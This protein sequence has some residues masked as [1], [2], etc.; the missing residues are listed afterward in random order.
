MAFLEGVVPTPTPRRAPGHGLPPVMLLV[1]APGI[2][3]TP[4]TGWVLLS[5]CCVLRCFQEK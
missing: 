1:S 3:E 4:C 5:L 2:K